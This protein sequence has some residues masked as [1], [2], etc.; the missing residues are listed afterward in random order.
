MKRLIQN[1]LSVSYNVIKLCVR[2]GNILTIKQK[3]RSII[4]SNQLERNIAEGDIMKDTRNLFKKRKKTMALN[5][6]Y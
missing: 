2:I 5:I 6:E 4:M 3:F 1:T